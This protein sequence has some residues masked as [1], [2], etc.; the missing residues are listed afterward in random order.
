MQDCISQNISLK[1]TNKTY[2]Q[3]LKDEGFLY[4]GQMNDMETSLKR[5]LPLQNLFHTLFKLLLEK[6]KH[7]HAGSV[8]KYQAG[9]HTEY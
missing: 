4:K 3:C 9:V 5:H 8:L 1:Q 2:W 6:Q 7:S